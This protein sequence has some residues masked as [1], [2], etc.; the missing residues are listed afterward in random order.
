[1]LISKCL[2]YIT[3]PSHKPSWY[4]DGQEAI[5]T[6]PGHVVAYVCQQSLA[7]CE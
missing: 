2:I 3:L 6:P 4:A 7:I 5:C 1:M